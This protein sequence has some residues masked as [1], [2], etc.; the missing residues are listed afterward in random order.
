MVLKIPVKE[1]KK[2]L[3]EN[4]TVRF[5]RLSRLAHCQKEGEGKV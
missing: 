4:I 1:K 2:H 3:H 5:Y